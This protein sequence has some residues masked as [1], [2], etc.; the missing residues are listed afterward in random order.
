MGVFVTLAA[1][2]GFV[3]LCWYFADDDKT[4]I[5]P[6][7]TNEEDIEKTGTYRIRPANDMTI[8]VE[9]C[10]KDGNTGYRWIE[11]GNNGYGTYKDFQNYHGIS[12]YDPFKA[13]TEEEAERFVKSLID[14][15]AKA[16]RKAADWQRRQV[17]FME[18]HPV[19]EIPPFKYIPWTEGE[20]IDW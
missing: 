11:I 9:Y 12:R 20:G 16:A 15:D 13:K 6:R 4:E 5:I 8:R 7:A 2:A 14:K 17:E 1:I 18:A 19:R 3:F 10:I